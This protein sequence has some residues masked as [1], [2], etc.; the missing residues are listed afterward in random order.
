MQNVISSDQKVGW[1]RTQKKD[2]AQF[3]KIPLKFVIKEFEQNNLI[4]RWLMTA[5]KVIQRINMYVNFDVN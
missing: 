3:T 2:K 1:Y 4:W 5:I